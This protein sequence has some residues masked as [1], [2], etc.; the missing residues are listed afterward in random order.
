MNTN[1]NVATLIQEARAGSGDALS[2]L[3][4]S[5]RTYLLLVATKE[6][7][8]QL[9]AKV[10][11][12]DVVQD[13]CLLAHRRFETFRGS[14]EAELRAWMRTVL[15]N[16][17]SDSRKKFLSSKRREVAR[18]INSLEQEK[19]I[20]S[21]DLT[22]KSAAL[23]REERQ[24]LQHAMEQ[25]SDNHRDVLRLRNWELLPFGEIGKQMGRS[26]DAARKLWSRALQE[27]EKAMR[28]S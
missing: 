24:Q 19:L 27:L 26:E 25:L 23:A 5:V 1:D 28:Q 11:A 20:H 21:P 3:I 15:L 22:P 13:A 9:R 12:S 2:K 14:T 16:S 4:E 18:E 17:L 7:S 6:T 10:A 8:P